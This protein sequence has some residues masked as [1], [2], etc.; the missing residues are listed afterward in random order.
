MTKSEKDV[1]NQT[2]NE[3]TDAVGKSKTFSIECINLFV[4][5]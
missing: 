1:L 3:L 4:D 5:R 2:I